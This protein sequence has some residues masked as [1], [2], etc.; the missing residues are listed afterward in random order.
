MPLCICGCGIRCMKKYV[1]GHNRNNHKPAKS[2][3][4]FWDVQENGCWLWS[5]GTDRDN[6]YGLYHI[7]HK[8]ILAHRYVYE[9]FK[10]IIPTALRLH[11][12]CRMTRCV[13]PDHLVPVTQAEN[14]QA[15]TTLTL[16]KALDIKTRYW[17]KLATVTELMVEYG[18]ASQTIYGITSGARWANAT[19]QN[20]V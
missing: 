15:E 18:L 19:K 14:M 3:E 16:A 13:N 12:T 5:G 8:T 1:R 9:K 17:S 20:N 4:S 2:I 10:G 11:H 6:K 7:A